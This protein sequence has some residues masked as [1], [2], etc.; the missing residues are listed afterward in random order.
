MLSFWILKASRSFRKF[1]TKRGDKLVQFSVT[2][3]ASMFFR[4]RVCFFSDCPFRSLKDGL[5]PSLTLKG[6]W[7]SGILN[8]FP[9]VFRW[10][11]AVLP[12]SFSVLFSPR[13]PRGVAPLHRDLLIILS[14]TRVAENLKRGSPERRG[15]QSSSSWQWDEDLG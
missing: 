12:S 13:G 15:F 4:E 3:E 8:E 9:G 10:Q 1:G 6:S 11:G 2:R 5:S 7:F 14:L